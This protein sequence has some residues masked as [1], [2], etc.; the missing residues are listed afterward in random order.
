MGRSSIAATAA[1]KA[2]PVLARAK[3]RSSSAGDADLQRQTLG[4]VDAEEDDDEEGVQ[5]IAAAI[6][7]CSRESNCS[8]FLA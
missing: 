7:L 8:T 4:L 5:P 1:D 2:S 3:E 6:Y